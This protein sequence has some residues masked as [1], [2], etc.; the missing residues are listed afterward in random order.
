MRFDIKLDANFFFVVVCQTVTE[1]GSDNFC[2][3]LPSLA[4]LW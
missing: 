4:P 2:G 3:R 1:K